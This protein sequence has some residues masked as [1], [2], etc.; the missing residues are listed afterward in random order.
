MCC[1]PK[2]LLQKVLFPG[3]YHKLEHRWRTLDG[4]HNLL[5]ALGSNTL[6]VY[7]YN[8]ITCPKAGQVR[9]AA[10]LHVFDEDGVE[11]FE[12]GQGRRRGPTMVGQQLRELRRIYDE[13]AQS[14]AE[15]VVSSADGDETRTTT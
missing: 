12:G 13:V 15:A 8:T 9:G 1:L 3:H 6:P 14:E 7:T 5:V 2:N 10:R 4:A 11:G